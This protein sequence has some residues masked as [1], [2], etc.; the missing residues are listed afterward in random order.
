MREAVFIGN[1]IFFYALLFLHTEINCKFYKFYLSKYG[2][3]IYL[4]KDSLDCEKIKILQ[5][6]NSEN[7]TVYTHLSEVVK[8]F[9]HAS[10]ITM[11]SFAINQWHCY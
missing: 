6:L 3:V 4:K 2:I 8:R 7:V 10:I 1:C 11:F 9:R 5:V